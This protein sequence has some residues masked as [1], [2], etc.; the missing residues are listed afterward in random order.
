MDQVVAALASVE[1][2]Q[3]TLPKFEVRSELP[4]RDALSAMGMQSAFDSGGFASMTDDPSVGLTGVIQQAFVGVNEAGTE[5]AAATAVIGGSL[6]LA[7]KTAT[8]DV[9]RPFFFAIRDRATR[10]LVF[11]GR[12]VDPAAS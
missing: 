10:A 4:L 8:L 12:V 2:L 7:T 11:V 9:T 3:V 6:N 1:L 5:A